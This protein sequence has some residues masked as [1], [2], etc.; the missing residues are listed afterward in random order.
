MGFQ[1][2]QR[3]LPPWFKPALITALCL[4][5]LGTAWQIWQA[6][7][8]DN[9]LGVN[10]IET[11][12]RRMGEMSLIF[13]CLT[14]AVTPLRKWL[15]VPQLLTV[16]RALG[17]TTFMYATLHLLAYSAWDQ[18][19]DLVEILKDTGKRPF[20]FVG[21]AA[22]LLMLP[23]ALTSW[24][25]AIKFVGGKRWTTLHKAVYAVALLAPLHFWWMKA[26]KQDF[27]RPALYGCILLVLLAWRAWSWWQKR[28]LVSKKL[29]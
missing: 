9:T 27:A 4:P 14:L 5:A 23:L 18:G 11:I 22:W 6:L 1:F 3:K 26:G 17:V 24:N 12:I 19:F 15:N 10:P 7:Q 25:A 2:K 16:R 29:H 20:I 8:G 21:M 28:S 13:L